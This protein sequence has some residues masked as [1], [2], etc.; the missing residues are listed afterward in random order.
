MLAKGTWGSKH[1]KN[2]SRTYQ[3]IIKNIPRTYQEH[4]KN[5]S[6]TYQ[7]HIKNISRTYQEHIK[8]ISPF[9]FGIKTIPI[10]QELDQNGWFPRDNP[11]IQ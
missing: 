8:N 7:Q 5:I 2:T 4:T 9:I 3:E 10:I 1:I 6:R 11:T